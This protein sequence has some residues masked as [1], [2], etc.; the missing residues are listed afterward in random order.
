[1]S[2]HIKCPQCGSPFDV[3]DV[4]SAD[5]EQKL[6]QQYDKQLQQ[7]LSKLE[8]EK[9]KLEEEQR[10]FEEKRRKE[11]ELFQQKLQ[12]EKQKL[13]A[14]LQ[15]QLR[16]SIAADYENQMRLLKQNAE[17]NEEK[18]KA[19][20]QKELE[21]LKKEQELKNKEQELEIVV[22]KKLLQERTHLTEL[23]RR[24]EA[25]RVSVKEEEYQFKMKELQM[26]LEE[27]RRLVEEMKR[28]AD[29]GSMQLQGEVQEKLLEEMLRDYFPFDT[30]SEVGKGVEGADCILTVRNHLGVECGKI[31]FE[32]K[33]T[34]T[35][36]SAWIDKL[37][38]DM[39]N[40]KMDVAVIVTQV[41][42]KDFKCFGE[43]DG[44][45][46]CSFHEVIALTTALR[47]TIIRIAETKK[48]EENKGEKMQ[49]LYSY[50]TGNEFR[51]QIEAIVE[52]F[53]SLKNSI[54]K[55]RV[56]MEKIWKERE[57]QLE[58]VLLSTSG[59][60][61][62]IKG[63]A[64]ASIGNIPLLEDGLAEEEEESPKMLFK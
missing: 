6:K 64:G 1:M 21:F 35:F 22:Q 4:L 53:L 54:T 3:E 50:L 60:Y 25:Q 45:W 40:Q 31:I 61:G 27:Q 44:V 5:V 19:A 12:Q 57:K 24:E 33:R 51:Q 15:Q 20:R 8:S 47:H 2:T 10:I 23:I 56:Q 38:V 37:K 41:Y 30:V 48:G 14:E 16:R 63:I 59:L 9:K 46:I 28:K 18:L 49:L 52:S 13:E 55:E 29:Q 39:R 26:Q 36:N 17:E 11:N 58:R 62:S 42:P 7:T 34:K 32:S 43:R